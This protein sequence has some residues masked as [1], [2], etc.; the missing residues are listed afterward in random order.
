MMVGRRGKKKGGEVVVRWEDV[1]GAARG[2]YERGM[3]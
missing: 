3:E 2:V 1:V